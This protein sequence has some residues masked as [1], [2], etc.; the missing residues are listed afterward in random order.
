MCQASIITEYL[1]MTLGNLR[2]GL[3]LG[4]EFGICVVYSVG[5]KY[6]GSWKCLEGRQWI[7]ELV[8]R[9]LLIA[10]NDITTTYC[11]KSCNE[12]V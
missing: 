10:T 8:L 7:S 3:G 2:P 1:S 4:H 5:T 9:K 6:V 11:I 12:Y